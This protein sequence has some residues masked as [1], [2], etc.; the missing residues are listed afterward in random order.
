M[1]QGTNGG[2]MRERGPPGLGTGRAEA[3]R[4]GKDALGLFKEEQEGQSG[5]AGSSSSEGE[6][7]GRTEAAAQG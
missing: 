1:K 2:E 5:S 7:V 3:L 6:L 4:W